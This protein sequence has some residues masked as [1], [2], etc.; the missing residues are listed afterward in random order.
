M[1]RIRITLT[2]IQSGAPK[3]PVIPSVVADTAS[4]ARSVRQI[5]EVL[6]LRE[7]VRG[8]PLDANVT[9]RD[10]YE[11]GL[12]E[13]VIDGKVYAAD[14]TLPTVKVKNV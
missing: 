12:V 4:V 1:K 5:K 9:W 3:V 11:N 10:L 8:S 13:F 14:V 6:E 7:G 2:D